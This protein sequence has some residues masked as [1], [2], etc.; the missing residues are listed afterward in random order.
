M[1]LL[2]S[3]L[4]LYTLSVQADDSIAPP[5]GIVSWW[6]GDGDAANL[7]GSPGTLGGGADFTAGMVGQ[8]FQFNGSGQYVA[9][10]LDVQP[11]ALPAT[12]WEAWVFPTTVN[13]PA[14]QQILSDDSGGYGRSVLIESGTSNFG[15]FTLATRGGG[16]E[17]MAAHRRGFHADEH[18]VLQ[19]RR[20]VFVWPCAGRTGF[21]LE[22]EHRPQSRLRRILRRRG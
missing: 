22:V 20:R 3:I 12:T 9:T 2:I 17:R 11:A 14:R 10:D 6:S 8:A 19:E 7:V 15:V 18:L 4:S 16:H 5:A 1:L 21:Q 13:A